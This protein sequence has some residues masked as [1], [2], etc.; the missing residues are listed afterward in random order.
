MHPGNGGLLAYT[1]SSALYTDARPILSAFAISVAP[2]PLA[3]IARTLA[4]SI[5]AGQRFPEE[6]YAAKSRNSP[7]AR[8]KAE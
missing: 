5:D 4:T 2:M 1:P 8:R 3:F 6:N 7:I